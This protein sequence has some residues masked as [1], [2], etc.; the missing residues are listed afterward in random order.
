MPETTAEDIQLDGM[1]SQ[2]FATRLRAELDALDREESQPAPAQPRATAPA[3]EQ[4]L[5]TDPAETPT[6]PTNEGTGE[7][8]A[9]A[10]T[11]PAKADEAKATET[12]P[13]EPRSKYAKEVERRERSWKAL[14]E[15]KAA[16]EAAMAKFK[17]EQEAFARQQAEW[18][19]RIAKEST[20]SYTAEQ[21]EETAKLHEQQGEFKL[22]ELLRAEAKRLRENPPA[23]VAP[24]GPKP[25][26]EDAKASLT[27]VRTEFPE[28][29]RPDTAEHAAFKQLALDRP[30]LLQVKDGPYLV[31]Q[32]VKLKIAAD[33]YAQAASRVP[34]L[35]KE[36]AELKAKLKE[37]ESLLAI[38]GGDGAP[39]LP[40]GQRSF[41]DLS[42]AE[43][44]AHLARTLR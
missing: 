6:E 40:T 3:V 26:S 36:V 9:Q 5:A 27:R 31:A 11:E 30:E 1:D 35:E 21:C 2:D 37:Q 44:E 12:K 7:P 22:A 42:E 15:Q 29:S 13:E 33:A 39:V 4:P 16:H 23:K 20:P 34:S 41:S 10:A 24:S 14:N 25:L 19:E 28:F 38:S 43:M 32:H 8:A 17:A 18:Q